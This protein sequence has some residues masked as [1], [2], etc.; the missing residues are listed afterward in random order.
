MSNMLCL[1]LVMFYFDLGLRYVD[2][3]WVLWHNR[4]FHYKNLY[5]PVDVIEFLKTQLQGP[6]ALHGYS[7]MHT[8]DGIFCEKGG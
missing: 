8:E 6:A 4:L 3:L 7:W 2:I 5:A 1:D